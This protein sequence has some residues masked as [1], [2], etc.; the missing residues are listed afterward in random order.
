MSI[1]SS[2]PYLIRALYAW[3]IDGGEDPYVEV[4]AD[5]FGVDIPKDSI[6]NG[7]IVLNLAPRAVNKFV[8]GEKSVSF[9]TRFSGVKTAIFLPYGA[10]SAIF[11]KD[12]GLGMRFGHEPGGVPEEDSSDSAESN[13][14][15][16]LDKRRA[17]SNS[18][19]V[20]VVEKKPTL[21]L[22]KSD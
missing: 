7:H 2:R 11:S 18:Q 19:G 15:R 13:N 8:M 22:I 9:T 6:K 17:D 14:P 12:S 1:G 20:S 16:R 3:I 10:I 4:D 21:R 5:Y